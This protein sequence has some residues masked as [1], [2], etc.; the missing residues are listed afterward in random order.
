MDA[1]FAIDHVQ[2][3][4]PPESGWRARDFYERVLGLR[5]LRDPALDRPGTLRYQLGAQRLDLHEGPYSGVAPQA[6]LALRV[7]G[8]RTLVATLRDRGQSVDTGGV[9]DVGARAYINDPFGNRIELIEAL[10]VGA[11]ET[12]Y[13]AEPLEFAI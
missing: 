3:P 8:L 11:I 7:R 10:L 1:I 12:G 5:E 2:L 6:H 9:P 13:E 4:I